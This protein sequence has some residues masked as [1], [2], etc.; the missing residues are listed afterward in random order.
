MSNGNCMKYLMVTVC[1][2]DAQEFSK[3]LMSLLEDTFSQQ[4]DPSLC[5]VIQ[6]QF[7]GHYDYVTRYVT[8]VFICTHKVFRFHY[9]Y[10][11]IYI[12]IYMIY[13]YLYF[14]TKPANIKYNKYIAHE[15]T[16]YVQL[17]SWDAGFSIRQLSGDRIVSRMYAHN[18][19][20]TAGLLNCTLHCCYVLQVHSMQQ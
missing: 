13:L 9:I 6:R 20:M 11:Y 15:T 2:Q 1:L 18:K 4:R 5:N 19:L 16:M 3:L 12:Y 17:D 7:L 8:C 14:L 10:I